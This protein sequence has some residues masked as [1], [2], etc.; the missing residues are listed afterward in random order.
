MGNDGAI[1]DHDWGGAASGLGSS[2]Q[3]TYSSV[4][5]YNVHVEVADEEG[6]RKE[7]QCPTVR[8]ERN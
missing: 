7:A 5:T 8:A 4:G 6:N 2:I 1:V 3:K